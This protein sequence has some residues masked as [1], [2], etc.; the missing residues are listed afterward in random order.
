GMGGVDEGRVALSAVPVRLS[1]GEL[2]HAGHSRPGQG[3]PGWCPQRSH[4]TSHSLPD[5][6]VA[7]ITVVAMVPDP[8]NADLDRWVAA[9]WDAGEPLHVQQVTKLQIGL[10]GE[11][12]RL[13]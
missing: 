11:Q 12:W 2:F 13:A 8:A 9:Q 10:D 1:W 6:A 3:L 5:V 4:H 7:G